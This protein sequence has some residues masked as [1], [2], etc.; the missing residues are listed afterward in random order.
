[1]AGEKVRLYELAK[2]MQLETKEMLA[3]CDQEQIVYKSIS[4]TISASEA[5]TLRTALRRVQ[6]SPPKNSPIK[7]VSSP[8]GTK[9]S[10]KETGK[11]HKGQ[12]ILSISAHR[13]VVSAPPARKDE[14][15]PASTANSTSNNS[16]ESPTPPT[17]IAP[18]APALKP[19]PKPRISPQAPTQ[20][21]TT[22][23]TTTQVT[24]QVSSQLDAEPVS[25]GTPTNSTV[26]LPVKLSAPPKLETKPALPQ[27]ATDAIATETSIEEAD[28]VTNPAVIPAIS[29]IKPTQ[30]TPPK[31]TPVSQD[32]E[33]SQNQ[34]QSLVKPQKPAPAELKAPDP[35]TPD[36]KTKVTS[37]KLV[38]KQK[39]E[40]PTPPSKSPKPVKNAVML[41]RGITAPNDPPRTPRQPPIAPVRP[42]AKE[43]KPDKPPAKT[44]VDTVSVVEFPELL[45][46]PVHK[47]PAKRPKG[48]TGSE[49][50]ELLEIQE[51]ANRAKAKRHIKV[52]EED[53]D[54][55]D[56]LLEG[57]GED[58]SQVA[59]SLARPSSRPKTGVAKTEAPPK[60]HKKNAPSHRDRSIAPVV[61]EIVKPT[62]VNINDSLTVAE[63]SA[64]LMV[65][66][67]DIIRSLFM[68]GVMVTINQSLEIATA[69]QVATDLGYEVEEIAAESAAKKVTEM[70]SADDLDHLHR[71]PPVVTIM[72][73]VDHGKTTL[74]DAIR[75]TKVAQGEAGGITQ[76]IGAYHVDVEQNGETQQ[77][78]F[79]DTPGHAAFTAMRARGTRVTDIAIL[80]VAADDGVQ[81]QTIEAISHAKAAKVPII[82]AINKI[83]KPTA[84]PD[85]IRQELTDHGLLAEEWGGDTIMVPV[86]AIKGENLDTLLEMILLVAEVEDLHANPD[87]SAKGTIIEAH[88]DK[89]RG[90]VATFL[91]QNGTLRVGD[92]FVA[93]P[94][95]GKV[96]AMIDDRGDRV[97]VAS[98]SFAVEVLGLSEVPAAGDEFEVFTDERQA[99]QVAERRADQSRQNRLQ[100]L[101]SR[102]IS[103]STA[104]AKVQEGELKELNIILK[105]DVQG[106]VEAIANALKQL[107][108]DEVQLCILLSAPG[109]ITEND[110]VLAAASEAVI[111]G[112]NTNLASGARA[113]A[114]DLGVD[115]RDYNI[116]YKLLEDVQGAME[117]LLEPELVEEHLGIAEVRAV[118]PVGRTNKV[119]G[120]YVQSGK[121]VR[122]CKIRIKR[123]KNQI[124]ETVL[125]SLKRMKDDVKEV[126]TGFECGVGLAKF[127][128]WEENDTIEAFRMVTKRRTLAGATSSS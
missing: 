7:K 85:R 73:H 98:P 71:R 120:C 68:K 92:V 57:E 88:L 78:V 119:A 15:S 48:K 39:P 50:A 128:D 75:K 93:G 38:L 45:D 11:E 101:A 33:N 23:V 35:K 16:G 47:V 32:K 9:E 86:S 79:L 19:A 81:P 20:V 52:F 51:R 31:S 59:L 53:E 117:G 5:D 17:A 63:L 56:L 102:R 3:A 41:D 112:F 55:A 121:L 4:S 100:A 61:E 91:V 82:V 87:R 36:S 43:E 8:D 46:K 122:N 113:C 58:G 62:K 44:P 89:S 42:I 126:A 107:P 96:R 84:Q 106:S 97:E 6:G 65:P 18:V 124:Y 40:V 80:V 115:V 54:D 123:G 94:V 105:A 30:P 76:H 118:F 25:N 64:R 116:I 2:E 90:P 83:D 72:G 12:Q 22:Q 10:P 114:D 34:S 77:V 125:D 21:A 26:A 37:P 66:E 29:L 111:L 13:P 60:I 70:L 74:L 14:P 109:E 104:S 108:Q 127:H 103:L 24:T 28:Q 95:L 99:R 1:M 27:T 110:V 69:K 49:D 67:T